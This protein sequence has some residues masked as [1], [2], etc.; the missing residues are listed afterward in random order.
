M[1]VIES[2]SVRV[3]LTPIA[4]GAS[5]AG[6]KTSGTILRIGMSDGGRTGR[7]IAWLAVAIGLA[8][9]LLGLGRDFILDDVVAIQ[10]SACVTGD[11]DLELILGSNFWCEQGHLRSIESWRP[12]TV[13]AWWLV[14]RLGT[15]SVAFTLLNAALYAACIH[16]VFALGRDLGLGDRASALSS[17]IFASLAVHVDAVAPAV[18]AADLWSALFVL[19]CIRAFLKGSASCVPLGALAV[20]SKESGVLALAC[21]GALHILGPKAGQRCGARRRTLLLAALA[22]V[23]VGVLVWRADVV[24][25]WAAIRVPPFVN[26]LVEVPHGTR[27][28]AALSLIGRYHRI[29]LL[30]G[31]FAG[32]YAYAAIGFGDELAWGDLVVGATCI[33]SWCALGWRFRADPAVR[34][35][36]AWLLGTCIFVSNALFVLPAM[37]A[38]RLF[39]LP[40]VALALLAGVALSRVIERGARPGLV[41]GAT[42][43]F[44]VVQAAMASAHTIRHRGARSLL[45]Q[46]V[47]TVPG[48]ARARMWLA[49][50]L[51]R[52]GAW[53]EAAVHVEVAGAVRPRWGVPRA[54][55]AVIADLDGRPEI[56][57]VL[58]REAL[59]LDPQEAEVAD[60][61]IQFLLRHGHVDHAR[62][63]YAAHAEARGRPDPKVTVP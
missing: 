49:V 5:P 1:A 20:L 48:N 36:I 4:W 52:E 33:V 30:G 6:G 11:L 61:F 29:T 40:T 32:D 15:S 54:V 63:V 39:L 38:E 43:V 14:W 18:G 34:V 58:F 19:H 56:A 24:G 44:V 45:E 16:A 51:L 55:A 9:A 62:F 47:E 37:F 46:T 10:E 42:T 35:L 31:P 59:E 26:P 41:Y 12:W 8:T 3:E 21:V 57:L 7:R 60:L 23:T 53:Q 13:L 28:L 25:S 27:F 17:L 50:R 2:S 22:V